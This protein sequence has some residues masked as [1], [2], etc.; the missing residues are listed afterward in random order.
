MISQVDSVGGSE[1][2]VGVS[3]T[4]LNEQTI[5]NHWTLDL[6]RSKSQWKTSRVQY[7]NFRICCS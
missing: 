3:L 5:V 1:G 6:R 2:H 4:V 7:E